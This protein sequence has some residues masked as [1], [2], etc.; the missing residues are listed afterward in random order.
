[1][2]R[3]A[4]EATGVRHWF[5]HA[6]ALGLYLVLSLALTWP[7]AASFTTHVTG[8]GIDDPALAWNLWWAKTRLVDQ[9]QPDIFH[10]GWMFYPVS[11]NLGFYTLTPLNGLLSVP[12]QTGLSLVVANNLLLLSS[13]VLGGYGVFL[14]TRTVWAKPLA[15]LT[16]G[17]AWT[18]CAAAGAFAA[19]ASAKL[20]YASL[21]QFNIAGSQWIPFA[22]LFLWRTLHARTG[23]AAARNGALAGVF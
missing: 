17:L 15:A 16:P 1:M 7:L 9:L 2:K 20:F 23:R 18:I 14:L 11:V 19:F 10:A 13:F 12:L 3:G 6:A 22:M 4:A 21:G 8:D 5:S